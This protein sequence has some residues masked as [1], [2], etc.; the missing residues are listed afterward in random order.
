MINLTLKEKH[1]ITSAIFLKKRSDEYIDP[2][3]MEFIND[4]EEDMEKETILLSRTQIDVIA[5]Y[6]EMLMDIKEY[7]K[8]EVSALQYKLNLLSDLP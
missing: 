3:H 5:Y 2:S 8:K 1:L 6:L 7:D 4:I